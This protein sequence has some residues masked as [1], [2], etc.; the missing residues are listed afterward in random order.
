MTPLEFDLVVANLA[1]HPSQCYAPLKIDGL[2]ERNWQMTN[3]LGN[4]FFQRN[5]DDL[6]Q[7]GLYLD[8][9]PHGAQLFHFQPII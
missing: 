8:V 4:E 7:A 1:P 2:A 6:A 9:P 5:G 3:L